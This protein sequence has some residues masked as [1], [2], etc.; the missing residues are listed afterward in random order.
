MAVP[1]TLRSWSGCGPSETGI[2]NG[3]EVL[4]IQPQLSGR[5]ASG[6]LNCWAISLTWTCSLNHSF[7]P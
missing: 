6:A 4:G 7:F 1:G 3:H 5:V 2:T